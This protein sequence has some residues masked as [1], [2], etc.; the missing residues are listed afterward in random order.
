MVEVAIAVAKDQV[1]LKHQGGDPE[2]V[3]VDSSPGL[4]EAK[5]QSAP[6]GGG[7]AV[8]V[9][10]LDAGEFFERSHS[11]GAIFGVGRSVHSEV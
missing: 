2:I 11:D 4:S 8:D 6:L 10:Q 7:G 3:D 1:V 9:E 5:T